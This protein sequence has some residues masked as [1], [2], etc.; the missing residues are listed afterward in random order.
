MVNDNGGARKEVSEQP[1]ASGAKGN[2]WC[3]SAAM[4]A[5]APP[6]KIV[7]EQPA[8]VDGAQIASAGSL[9]K[10]R[11]GVSQFP[12][13][14]WG[15]IEQAA[16]AAEQYYNPMSINED[17][18]YRGTI[19]QNADGTYSA[20]WAAPGRQNGGNSSGMFTLGRDVADF[21][22][23]GKQNGANDHF[24]FTDIYNADRL[25]DLA[26]RPIPFIVGTPSG[27]ILEYTPIPGVHRVSKKGPV[28][29]DGP[30]VKVIGTTDTENH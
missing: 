20:T 4:D 9:Q 14:R 10:P 23:H 25:S 5:W 30:G 11:P 19:Y 16:V 12:G 3:A 15:T 6:V 18:E 13:T 28:A 24:S 1:A 2:Q 7:N 8:S 22:T 17:R 21:H 27:Q 29:Y 26:H